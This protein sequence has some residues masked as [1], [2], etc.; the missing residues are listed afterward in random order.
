[1]YDMWLLCMCMYMYNT[2]SNDGLLNLYL[3]HMYSTDRASRLIIK[4]KLVW[5][6]LILPIINQLATT[7][8]YVVGSEKRGNWIKAW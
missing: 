3:I 8:N 4:T 2:Y 6:G 7:H 5:S 1:M